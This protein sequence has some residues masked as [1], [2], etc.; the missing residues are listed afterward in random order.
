M[1][2]SPRI[3]VLI[4]TYKQSNLISRA[5]DSVLKQRE[6]VYEIC[7]SDD[8]SPDDTFTILQEYKKQYPELIK[9]HQNKENLGI[10]MNL[11]QVWS[12]PTGD[13]VYTLAG[14]DECG[15]GWLKAVTDYVRNNN[16]SMIDRFCI[17]GDYRCQYP[18][19]DSLV[20]R[21]NAL[22]TK[23]DSLRLANRNK[24]GNRSVCSSIEVLRQFSRVSMGRSH[25]AES[26]QARQ[27]QLFSDRDYYI[28]VVGNV[29]HV[30]VGVS[31]HLSL[32]D[33]LDRLGIRQ[34]TKEV[35]L[36]LGAQI[37]R[38]DLFFFDYCSARVRFKFN[39]ELFSLLQMIKYRV[40]SFD[41]RIDIL[42]FGYKKKLFSILRRLPHKRPLHFVV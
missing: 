27:F 32:N 22:N 7:V 19:G 9:I 37:P 20:F 3:S 23:I 31:S 29:Y 15:D 28:P 41:F 1:D 38:K 17:Y 30:G 10:F 14:D 36:K 21:N 35:L 8:C 33:R 39:H 2:S 25:I 40:L 26:A 34:Y 12:M 5:L 6:Y 4:I 24:I 16:L 11:E 42:K 13:I 18:N